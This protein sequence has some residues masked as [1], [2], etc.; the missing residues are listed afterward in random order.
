MAATKTVVGSVILGAAAT[1][2]NAFAAS[3]APAQRGATVL[4]GNAQSFTQA[5]GGKPSAAPATLAVAGVALLGA[6]AGAARRST[7]GRAR[8]AGVARNFNKEAQIGAQEPLG[9][10]DPLGFCTDEAAFKD[11]R[12]KELKHGRL[13]MMGA[14]GMLTQSVVQVPGMEGV[15]KDV[16]ACLVGNGQVGFIGTL[17]IIAGLEAAVF[18]QDE[19]KEPGNFGNPVPWFDDYSPEMRAREINNGRIAMFAAIGQIAAGLYTG[20]AGIEQF[21]V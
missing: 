12:A 17:A 4:R 16:T 2:A 10:F 3:G 7:A 14:L 11:L 1:G 13:A 19:S 18:V 20:K 8:A 5:D 21:S 15:P 6:S 9:F